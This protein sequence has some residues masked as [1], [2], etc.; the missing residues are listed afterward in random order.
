M[1][2]LYVCLRVSG[3]RYTEAM[4]KGV[5]MSNFDGA[6]RVVE[7]VNYSYLPSIDFAGGY[8]Y[9]QKN[10]SIFDSDQHLPVQ[11]FD[12]KGYQFDTPSFIIA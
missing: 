10:I 7:Y 6:R 4:Q 12:G 3:S 1:A 11:V 2:V 9:N 8:T 5:K